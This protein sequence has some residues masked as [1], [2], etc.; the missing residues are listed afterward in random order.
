MPN[1]CPELMCINICP[2]TPKKQ[3]ES[4]H[5]LQQLSIEHQA[6]LLETPNTQPLPLQK[7]EAFQKDLNMR[8]T[9]S[10]AALLLATIPSVLS[11]QHGGGS[12][13]PPRPPRLG[14]VPRPNGIGGT[15]VD[16]G[17][18]PQSGPPSPVGAAP[19]SRPPAR[20][21]R[22]G[23]VPRPDIIAGTN[24]DPGPGPPQARRSLD[25][26]E[27]ELFARGWEMNSLMRRGVGLDM[28]NL[29]ARSAEPEPE[30]EAEAW[31]WGWTGDEWVY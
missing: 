10:A 30:P 28:Y 18:G 17:P 23:P 5:F 24:V 1:I 11:M 9:A 27:L 7:P 26:M 2:D 14:P 3:P 19:A 31:G 4:K 13:P 22:A 12:A 29:V 6:Y 20:P 15:N 8:F 16:P 21:P 25:D